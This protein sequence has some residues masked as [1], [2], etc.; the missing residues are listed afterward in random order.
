MATAVVNGIRMHYRRGSV[1]VGGAAGRGPLGG[2][3]GAGRVGGGVRLLLR[4]VTFRRWARRDR[5]VQVV[6]LQRDG[7]DVAERP[8]VRE[9]LLDR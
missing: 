3:A 5:R 7:V 8:L 2:V 1:R 9:L 6:E 4:L